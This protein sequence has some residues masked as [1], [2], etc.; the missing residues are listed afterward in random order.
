MNFLAVALTTIGYVL[1]YA[2]VANH[3]KFAVRPFMGLRADAYDAENLGAPV[4][5]DPQEAVAEGQ[6]FPV[7][8]VPKGLPKN[9]NPI[10]D[11]TPTSPGSGVGGLAGDIVRPGGGFGNTP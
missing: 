4:S 5:M 9:R 3:G 11:S 10:G 6:A 1:V 7:T 2:S 8:G